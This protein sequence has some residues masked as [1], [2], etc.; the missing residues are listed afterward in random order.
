MDESELHI[1][2][3][4][5]LEREFL[6]GD[7][8]ELAAA[9]DTATTSEFIFSAIR[10]L[11]YSSAK[12]A[13]ETSLDVLAQDLAQYAPKNTLIFNNCDGFIGE[14]MGAVRVMRLVE[15][16]GFRHT[17]AHSDRIF[18]CIDK[19]RAKTRLMRHGV[20]TP[21]FQ[22]FEEAKGDLRLKFPAIVKPVAEDASMG[23]DLES[24][25]NNRKALFNRVEYV[26]ATY[27]QPAIVEEFIIG[28][29][30]A[31]SLW[32]NRIIEA[33]PVSEEDF[34]GIS[35]PLKAFLTYES[36]WVESSPYFQEIFSRPAKLNPKT[37]MEVKEAAIDA[38]RA[39]GLRD[40]GRVD[41]RFR[42]GVPFVIDVNE[43]PDLSPE[44]GFP[45]TTK[46]AGYSYDD[47][48][49]EILDIA[50]RREGWRK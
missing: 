38:Y 27:K 45:R 12:I 43:I 35:D 13:I 29:E 41:I 26:L 24:V 42:D 50:L 30:F 49:E 20:P 48:I 22:V 25:V 3:V 10:R 18:D 32:G 36:K 46:M 1:V 4:F 17:G 44:S 40:F 6:R 11:G 14:N 9:Q 5:N 39:M 47:M 8:K 19:A 2:V 31:V 15:K 7:P 23:I 28:R 16:L 21:P 37:E 34:G 33:L